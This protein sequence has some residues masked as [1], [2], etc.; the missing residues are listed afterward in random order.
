MATIVLSA[1][2]MALGGSLGGSVLGLSTA[3]IGRAAGAMVGRAIDE[4]LLGGG[5]APVET[6]RVDRFRL[7]GAS[8]GS[9]VARLFGAARL[10]G[11]VIWATRFMESSSTTGGGGKG[12]PAAPEVT[13]LSY[14]I[15]LAISLCEGPITG[16]GRIWAD[17]AEIARDS[18]QMSVY[19]GTEDQQ[20]DPRM[21]AV[22]GPGRV[23]AY[24]GVAYVVIEDLDLS[25]FGNRVPQFSF[26]VFRPAPAREGVPPEDVARVVK[27]VALIPGT[28]EYSLAIEPV[29][30]SRDFGEQMAANVNTPQ[31]RADLLVSLDDLQTQ[32][33]NL[34][35]VSLVV[36]W[37]GDDLRVNRCTVRPKV[38]QTGTDGSMPWRVSGQGRGAALVVPQADGR[39]VYG[40]TP[41]DESV[42]QAIGELKRRGLAVMFYPFILMDQMAGNALPNPYGGASQ[43]ALPWRGRITTSIAPGRPG[44]PD[45]TAAAE[46]EV[47]A[48]FGACQPSHFAASGATVAYSGPA[49]WSFRRMILHYARLCALAGGVDAFCIGTEMVGLTTIRGA[50]NSFPAVA[51]LRTLAAEVKA[52]LPMAKLTYAADWSE[53]RGYQPPGE[54]GAF[55][56]HL[57]PLWA[58]PA[59]DL[60]GVDNYLPLSDWREGEDHL[61]ARWGAI[62]DVDY[63][64]SNVEGGELFDW[65]YASDADRA[66]QVRTPITDEGES[67]PWLWRLK[68]YRGWWEHLHHDRAGGVRARTPTAW[69]PRSK[70]F[71]FTELGCAALDKGT[72]QPNK[73]LDPKSSE[74]TLPFFSNGLR[75]DLIQASYLRAFT[76]HW[77]RSERNPLSDEYQGRMI[78]MS[79]A[80]VWAWDARPFP[81]FPSNAD[82]WGDGPNYDRGHWLNGRASARPLASV[83]EEIC[84]GSGLAE[85][86]TAKLHGLVRGLLLEEAGTGREAIQP[87]MLAHGF[88][89]VERDGR[90]AFVTRTGLPNAELV[91]EELVRDPEAEAVLLRARAPEAE[92]VGRV[93][94]SFLQHGGDYA[95]VSADATF[96]DDPVPSLSRNALPVVMLREEGGVVAERWLAEARLARETVR[97]SLPPSRGDLGPADVVRLDGALWRIDRIEDKGARAVEATRVDPETWRPMAGDGSVAP[98]PAVAAPVPIEAVFLDLPLVTGVEAPHAPHVAFASDPWPGSAALWSS[99]EDAGYV[100]ALTAPTPATVGTTLNVLKAAPPSLWDRG[101]ALRVK[102]VRG[103]LSSTSPD[104]VLA[105]AGA[106][107]IGDGLT[108]RWEVFQFAE[109]ELVAS[110]T[111][112]LR[113]RL[114]GQAGTDGV[115][116]AEWPAGS[117]VVL[118]DGVPRQ[119]AFPS[120]QREQERH[121]R[122]GPTARPLSDPSWRHRAEAFR[123]I[124]LRPYA[125]CHLATRPSGGALDLSWIRRTRIEGD[126]WTPAEVPLGEDREAYLVR[127]RRGGETLREAEVSR[128]AWTYAAS[129]RGEDGPGPVT[130]EVAQVSDRFG[131][132]PFRSV[133]ASNP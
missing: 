10:A 69:K 24:R 33:P 2:G 14:S 92:Q 16:V 68:D 97:F 57:D 116:P 96:P 47:Q 119:W 26:E 19:Q 89:A 104:R 65:F 62:H 15:S 107:A 76:R 23:P 71:W 130:I 49:E 31:G 8:E 56:F 84:R 51:R 88:D 83:V 34:E 21:E 99:D 7:T 59:I 67:E 108:D 78:D 85:V 37:F 46:A 102:L 117:R 115:M 133:P 50:S 52:I 94:V 4:R 58:D 5:A 73:F 63:L 80:H 111:Y 128:P 6:G 127:V 75:D 12:A 44:S 118:L 124:G 28:G 131:P 125:V 74:S 40:G 105:G 20:P 123:G 13:T 60:I 110:K 35:S 98:A 113:L 126:S 79:R 114:R 41:T 32:L 109:A 11:Q 129:L 25:R 61:D 81:A 3:V 55:H 93:Q 103:A 70:P 27:G 86:D 36:C 22:E 82:L 9:S 87:L 100:P 120:T 39:S 54:P 38:E 30:Q 18:L 95:S 53:A 29:Y 77:S 42:I 90:L 64:M 45:G 132:G 101:P 17:G 66:A 72:N 112:D 48:F 122:W 121:Y 91:E 43:P 1:A 106:M